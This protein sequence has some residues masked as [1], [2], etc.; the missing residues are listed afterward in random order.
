MPRHWREQ[1]CEYEAEDADAFSWET[2]NLSARLFFLFEHFSFFSFCLR[3]WQQP[4]TKDIRGLKSTLRCEP[5]SV[6]TLS[7]SRSDFFICWR[8]SY[9]GTKPAASSDHELRGF[10]LLG[11]NQSQQH[12]VPQTRQDPTISSTVIWFFYNLRFEPFFVSCRYN[13]TFLTTSQ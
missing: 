11:V 2:L 3:L 5:Q 4:S 9:R 12:L 6:V 10:Y 1:L 13:R 7:S 8:P